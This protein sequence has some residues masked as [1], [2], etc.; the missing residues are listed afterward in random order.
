M[1][2]KWTFYV[3]R[4]SITMIVVGVLAA[5]A[6]V[7]NYVPQSDQVHVLGYTTTAA[8]PFVA[9]LVAVLAGFSFLAVST[10]AGLTDTISAWRK[11]TGRP[12]S[13]FPAHEEDRGRLTAWAIH[14]ILQPLARKAIDAFAERDLARA[15]HKNYEAN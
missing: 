5:F 10:A 7:H 13:E 14:D 4:L 6:A 8:V 3:H 1:H 15:A 11:I 9:A 2:P 12:A